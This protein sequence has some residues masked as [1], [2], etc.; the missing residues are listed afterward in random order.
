[1][2]VYPRSEKGKIDL[3]ILSILNADSPLLNLSKVSSPFQ[4]KSMNDFDR[5]NR[6]EKRTTTTAERKTY[7]LKIRAGGGKQ[8]K[9]R[10]G[11]GEGRLR[12]R[13]IGVSELGLQCLSSLSLS[14]ALFFFF[15]HIH[16]FRRGNNQRCQSKT[17]LLKRNEKRKIYY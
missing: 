10:E 3:G 11:E 12:H 5:S 8:R 16:A 4:T 13:R 9:K 2:K 15:Y 1:M 7:R 6:S 17:K 14:L